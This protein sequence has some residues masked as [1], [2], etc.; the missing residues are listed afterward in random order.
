L[1]KYKNYKKKKGP[2]EVSIAAGSLFITIESFLLMLS[3]H[4]SKSSFCF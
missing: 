2:T 1:Y 3:I 4:A